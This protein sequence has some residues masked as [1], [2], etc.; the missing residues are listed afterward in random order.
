MA[1]DWIIEQ[2]EKVGTGTEG[3]SMCSSK[4][5]VKLVL[6]PGFGKKGL[7]AALLEA[8]HPFG[9]YQEALLH[10]LGPWEVSL[11]QNVLLFSSNQSSLL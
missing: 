3:G 2:T 9:L 1:V 6:L 7:L 10:S 4:G 8:I 11:V 5:R